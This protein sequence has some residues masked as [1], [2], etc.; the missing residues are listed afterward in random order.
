MS[1]LTD[2]ILA[3][4]ETGL[5]IAA[6]IITTLLPG[7]GAVVTFATK[8]AAGVAAAVPDAVALYERIQSGE[9]PTQQEMDEWAAKEDASYAAL[10][11]DIAE[12]KA[13]RAP[14]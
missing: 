1:K 9:V 3:L 13:N 12:H 4:A 6:N 2:T 5:P 14:E 7:S 10:M 11:A 8:L